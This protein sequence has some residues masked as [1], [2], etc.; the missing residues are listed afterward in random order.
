MRSWLSPLVFTVIGVCVLPPASAQF[1]KGAVSRQEKA[2][3]QAQRSGLIEKFSQLPVEER[4]RVLERLPPERRKRVEENLRDYQNLSPQQKEQWERFQNLPPER[5]QAA[6]K[7]FR[8]MNALAVE[9][10]RE[11]RRELA[12]LRRMSSEER[13]AR[14]KSEDFRAQFNADER[15]ILTELSELFPPE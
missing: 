12:R 2:A 1:R 5:Q 11:V 14:L 4:R 7:L 10:K 6:R 15:K 9:R 8:Q 13:Q 3:R